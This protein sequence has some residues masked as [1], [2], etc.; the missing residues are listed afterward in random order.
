MVHADNP[1][2]LRNQAKGN[3]DAQVPPAGNLLEVHDAYVSMAAAGIATPEHREVFMRT[4]KTLAGAYGCESIVLAGTDLA[5]VFKKDQNPGPETFDCA[6][7]HA[8]AIAN[9]AWADSDLGWRQSSRGSRLVRRMRVTGSP[10]RPTLRAAGRAGTCV[11]ACSHVKP[12]ASCEY[13]LPFRRNYLRP[14]L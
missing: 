4:G 11:L 12:E 10:E 5:L 2:L 3:A 13:A 7:A 1:T 8:G 9:R 6:E 14:S